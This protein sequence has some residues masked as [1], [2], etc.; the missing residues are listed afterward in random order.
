MGALPP[1]YRRHPATRR[2]GCGA[3][4]APPNWPAWTPPVSWPTRSPNGTWPDPA[5]SP[6]SSTPASATGSAPWSRSRPAPGPRAVPALADPDRQ[7][8]VA[9][10]AALMDARTDRI[11][12]HA[13]G[14]PP[15]WAIAALGPVPAHPLAR[16]DWQKRA[17]AIG[18]WRELSGY[19][20]PADPIGPEPAA[21]APDV[22]RRLAPGPGRPR[23][24]RRPR[25]PRHARRQAAAPARHLP[26]RDRLGPPVRRGRA[27]PGPRR[28][29]GRPPGRPARR[30][31]GPRRRTARR[32]RPRRGPAQAGRRLPGPGAGLP[33]ARGRLR[34]S[35]WPTAPT[36]TRPPAPSA[37]WPSPPT[38]NC[39]AAT[40]ASTSRR[41]AP[42]NPS[43]PPA[44]SAT[45]SPS[46]RTQPPGEIDQ[47][48]TDL[49]AGHRT[50]AD[51]LADRQS[52]TIPSEDPDYGDL[53]P[54]FPAWTGPGREPILQPPRP[55]IPPSPQILQ[56]RDGPRRRL[57]SRG[58]TVAG[59]MLTAREV[60]A[61]TATGIPGARP[62]PAPED[63][64][65][66]TNV[67][68]LETY[69]LV[70]QRCSCTARDP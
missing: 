63:P 58:L 17:A 65:P 14:H 36:G 54:A 60:T 42:P 51:R 66:R 45:S 34:R 11:G 24:G 13:A 8:Y 18:A 55:E 44:P 30:R 46:P 28:R 23:P 7:A 25:R 31:R 52:Q 48:I 40:P 10:I 49:A 67:L 9:E 6:P 33:A 61:M 56:K 12:E 70:K 15:P 59:C 68:A 50:F 21:A 16:L 20:H 53:G 57:G 22:A 29:L 41:C 37:S 1:G 47:W 19:D 2:G 4:C 32:P 35:R 38:P 27:A 39:A 64:A 5:T 3:P 69:G 62:R 43:P 26:R